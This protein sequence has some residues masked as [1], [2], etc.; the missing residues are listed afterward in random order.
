MCFGSTLIYTQEE[1]YY[2]TVRALSL[3]VVQCATVTNISALHVRRLEQ[4]TAFNAKTEQFIIAK[5]SGNA[6]K[7][8]NKTN[9]VLHQRSLQLQNIT[10]RECLVD[11]SVEQRRYAVGMTD[12]H[13]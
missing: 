1:L 13:G 2:S 12:N 4:N 6:L 3:V 11:S 9:S 7:Q 10:L 8:G 5:I